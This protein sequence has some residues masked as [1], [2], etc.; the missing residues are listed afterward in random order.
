MPIRCYQSITWAFWQKE[1]EDIESWIAMLKVPLWTSYI[2][3]I[4]SLCGQFRTMPDHKQSTL[5]YCHYKANVLQMQKIGGHT[6]KRVQ[7][8]KVK[9]GKLSF[10][11]IK[12]ISMKRIFAENNFRTDQIQRKLFYTKTI[13][14]VV[15]INWNCTA[16]A[17][18][19]LLRGLFKWL[20]AVKRRR[21]SV[22]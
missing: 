17:L 1:A 8:K 9:V 5:K 19:S 10:V 13:L 18:L 22:L 2:I 20:V 7:S 16:I 15:G 12:K 21:W 4:I 11:F 3:S 6:Y 14:R